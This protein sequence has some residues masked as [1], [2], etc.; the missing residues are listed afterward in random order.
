LPH[1]DFEERS[2]HGD[3]ADSMMEMD[4]RVGQIEDCVTEL[5]IADDT[6]FIFC[7]EYISHTGYEQWSLMNSNGP[8]FRPPYRGTAGPVRLLLADKVKA[9]NK[10]DRHLPYGDGGKPEGTFHDPMARYGSKWSDQQ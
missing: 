4:H 2:G 5:G 10:V 7:S 1:T 8:E 3:F 6:I 9:K